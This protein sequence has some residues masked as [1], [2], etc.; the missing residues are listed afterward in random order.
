VSS[1][2]IVAMSSVAAVAW[3]AEGLKPLRF[4]REAAARDPLSTVVHTDCLFPQYH[5]FPTK[6]LERQHTETSVPFSCGLKIL[7]ISAICGPSSSTSCRS[8]DPTR[9]LGQKKVSPTF[10]G[11]T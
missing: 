4:S 3:Q 9:I 11:A 2:G 8:T 7:V 1:V 10:C 5:L 6:S